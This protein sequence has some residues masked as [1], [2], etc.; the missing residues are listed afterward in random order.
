MP[1]P[2]PTVEMATVNFYSLIQVYISIAP[3]FLVVHINT[4]ELLL[5]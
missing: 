4:S 2:S 1:F 3:I 5:E